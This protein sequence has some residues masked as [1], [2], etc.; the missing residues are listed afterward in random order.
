VEWSNGFPSTQLN[1]S[2][3]T[4]L[5]NTAA[6]FLFSTGYTRFKIAVEIRPFVC[7]SN[8][9]RRSDSERFG[10]HGEC[11]SHGQIFVTKVFQQP[12]LRNSW[13]MDARV[14]HMSQVKAG[15]F[16]DTSFLRFRRTSMGIVPRMR[17]RQMR[18]GG[19]WRAGRQILRIG[20]RLCHSRYGRWSL[21]VKR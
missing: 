5:N 19:I 12:A 9:Q 6:A 15:N 8:H 16:R 18:S 3:C 14:I 4:K 20:S 7:K 17:W 2:D 1:S 13:S 21:R 11:R 10:C